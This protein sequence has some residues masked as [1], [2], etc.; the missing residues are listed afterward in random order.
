MARAKSG[1]SPKPGSRSARR[2]PPATK[3]EKRAAA[4]RAKTAR[5]VVPVS[6][7]LAD[8][9]RMVKR[10]PVSLRELCDRLGKSPKDVE[11]LLEQARKAGTHVIVENDHIGLRSH[12]AV[13]SHVQDAGIEPVVGKQQKIGVISDTHLGSK[14][15]LRAQLQDFIHHAYDQGV[16]EIVHP[17][18][19]LEG[20]YRHAKFELS[21]VGLEDQTHDLYE[22]LPR[23]PGLTYHAIT[24]NHDW[25]FT[26]QSGV[27]VGDFIRR[28][29]NDMGRRDFFC[30]GDRGA[31]IKLR[32]AVIDLWH[33]T[34]GLGYA[35]SYK[36][37]RKI[38]S[39]PT[40]GKPNILLVGHYHT[41]AYAQERGV[42]GLL[43]PTF[44]GGQSA[45]GRSLGST[46]EI[47][48]LVLKWSLTAHGTLRDFIVE[49]RTYFE[50]EVLHEIVD[51]DRGIEVADPP[52][53]GSFARRVG[54]LS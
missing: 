4:L 22:T 8:V 19:M 18:D 44:Q 23:L 16:R 27:D 25:T 20:D 7:E 13:P 50:R 54:R 46:P 21:H 24:G 1:S 53:R 3:Q 15:C 10:G 5:S 37:Q 42:H 43:C 31:F 28:Y 32:G 52:T 48:G 49:R 29:F 30:Y 33:P 26:D 39:Y 11:R 41:Y 45:F 40:G 38:D 6:S 51:N 17:G 2:K 36:L 47:G 34:G 9:Y 12:A 35:K 14:Y